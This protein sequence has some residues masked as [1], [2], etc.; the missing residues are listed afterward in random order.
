MKWSDQTALKGKLQIFRK[1]PIHEEWGSPKKIKKD[2]VI[3]PN[4]RFHVLL[5]FKKIIKI[6]DWSTNMQKKILWKLHACKH[7]SLGSIK[8]LSQRFF[9]CTLFSIVHF[10]LNLKNYMHN[11]KKELNDGDWLERISPAFYF[12]PLRDHLNKLG[13]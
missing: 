11:E 4:T 3:C 2:R 8:N 12:F 5:Y 13:N 9:T 1:K 6:Y 10:F 7:A